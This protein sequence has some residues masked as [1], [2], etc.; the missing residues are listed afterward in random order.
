MASCFA[1]SGHVQG[2]QVNETEDMFNEVQNEG[3]ADI[4]TAIEFEMDGQKYNGVIDNPDTSTSMMT[5]GYQGRS[6][7]TIL[8]TRSQFPSQPSQKGNITV[9]APDMF[10][11]SVWARKQ[12][13]P[14]GA[15][16][17]A[18]TILHQLTDR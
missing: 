7:I 10:A 13:E 5:G 14:Y 11:Q 18:I 17:Y 4:G 6:V 2:G 1:R 16:H 3:M 9:T 8:A 15:A 12:V